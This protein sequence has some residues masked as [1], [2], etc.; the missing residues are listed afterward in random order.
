MK[1]T[2]LPFLIL[3]LLS[4][5]LACSG[6]QKKQQQNHT[7][8]GNSQSQTLSKL[9]SWVRTKPQMRGFYVGVGQARILPGSN[10]HVQAAR[11][12]ALKDLAS[13]IQVNIASTSILARMET[14]FRFRES[15]MSEIRAKTELELENFE[16]YDTFENEQIYA[17]MYRL[18]RDAYWARIRARRD[19]ALS[20]AWQA[21]L[22][23]R[24]AWNNGDVP[25]AL[26]RYVSGMMELEPFFDQELQFMS[27][28]GSVD[29]SALLMG[30]ISTMLSSLRLD[31]APERM[32]LMAGQSTT[33]SPV[34]ITATIRTRNGERI[35]AHSLPLRW[36]S[37]ANTR[38]GASATR[39]I[40]GDRN[41]NSRGIAS[42][43]PPTVS[44][45][46]SLLLSA[47]AEPASWMEKTEIPAF[48]QTYLNGFTRNAQCRIT[49]RKPIIHLNAL[50]LI[51]GNPAAFMS[52]TTTVQQYL[53]QHGFRIVRNPEEADI[54]FEVIAETEKGTSQ[55]GI[56]IAFGR[57]QLTA[58]RVADQQ[59][60]FNAL[61]ERLK[62]ADLS[63]EAAARRAFT[64]N[65]EEIQKEMDRFL[66]GD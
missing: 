8:I 59:V 58:R 32:E 65:R 38:S 27:P 60:I 49:F 39:P 19:Q 10:D 50:E 61:L 5:N 42:A 64:S 3:S 14:D 17:I 53:E 23:G 11:Q 37:S 52:V 31:M 28:E 26:S 9:P 7:V 1:A 55:G 44:P 4:V 40:S 63:F 30:E 34:E 16:V 56:F 35:P 12:I 2:V 45:E 15:Y 18:D 47:L 54:L 41:T 46:E 24:D 43:N 13:E 6:K 20:R 51:L 66:L 29:M 22:D 21:V 25:N 57:V 33:N 62:G 36:I 48:I